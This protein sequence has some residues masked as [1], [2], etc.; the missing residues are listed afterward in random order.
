VKFPDLLDNQLI[1]TIATIAP[2]VA[3]ALGGPL[4]GLAAR[5]VAAAVTGNAEA[6]KE[7]WSASVAA[8]SP[9]ALAALRKAE[10]DFQ[11]HLADLG[12]ERERI[13]AQD[14]DSARQRESTV[15][16]WTPR[17]LAGI[18]ILGWMLAQYVVLTAVIEPSM[19]ELAARVLGTC[20]AALMLVLSYY[21]GSS[22]GS[23]AKNDVID[24]LSA[25]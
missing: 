5:T 18:V 2:T 4:A 11:A 19:R 10:L 22:A 16:D 20:D 25:K 9:E 7:A 23:S 3:E 15:G 8:Q 24:R 12:I 1:Q 13:A 6:T 17:I 21:F 14:R